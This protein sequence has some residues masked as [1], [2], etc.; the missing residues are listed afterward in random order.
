MQCAVAELTDA[1]VMELQHYVRAEGE[2]AD[3]VVVARKTG[4]LPKRVRLCARSRPQ[5]RVG[6]QAQQCVEKNVCR[7]E[8]EVAVTEVNAAAV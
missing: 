5:A 3:V 7:E 6:A 4:R 8:A 2:R 1:E